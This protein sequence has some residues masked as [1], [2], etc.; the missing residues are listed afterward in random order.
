MSV[1]QP[2]PRPRGDAQPGWPACVLYLV[3]LQQGLR[4][5]EGAGASP[6]GAGLAR[7]LREEEAAGVSP[8]GA[9]PV[10]GLR[11]EE[12][13]GASPQRR[14]PRERVLRGA[15]LA[16]G[17]R[18]EEATGASPQRSGPGARPQ[19]FLGHRARSVSGIFCGIPRPKEILNTLFY[20]IDPDK[21]IRIYVLNSLLVIW[22]N[23]THKRKTGD[24]A[25][26]PATAAP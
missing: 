24:F 16:R 21:F 22:E 4:E 14:R 17:L 2:Q 8:R 3:W 10:P 7:G 20:C 23:S 6:R 26:F 11:E 25:P 5:E 1:P 13:T 12:A 18:E 15:G 19:S 9:G